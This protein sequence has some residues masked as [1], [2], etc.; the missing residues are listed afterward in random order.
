MLLFIVDDVSVPVWI[1]G[2]VFILIR[3]SHVTSARF[4]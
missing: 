1:S 3:H 4:I 2:H